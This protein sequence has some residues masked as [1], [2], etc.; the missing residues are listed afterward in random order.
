MNTQILE[1]SSASSIYIPTL[2]TIVAVRQ[3]TE[4][5]KVFTIELPEDVLIG[6]GK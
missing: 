3:E 2:A 6:S 1:K 5:E 4:L